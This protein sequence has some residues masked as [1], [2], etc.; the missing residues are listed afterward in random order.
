MLFAGRKLVSCCKST[1]SN[2]RTLFPRT[3]GWAIL[4]IR[5]FTTVFS[6]SYWEGK[7]VFLL[8]A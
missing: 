1:I 8:E 2:L 5:H 4:S 7:D 3:S 6:F